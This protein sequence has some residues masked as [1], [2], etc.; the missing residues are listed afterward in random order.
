MYTEAILDKVDHLPGRK[1][2]LTGGDPL[3]HLPW[4][5]ELIERLLQSSYE[6]TIETNGSYPIR[7]YG[8]NNM[9]RVAT[10]KRQG[11]CTQQQLSGYGSV[12]FV[13]DYKLPSSEME[14]KM[15]KENWLDLTKYDVVKFVIGT[16]EDFE[17]ALEVI[18]LNNHCKAQMVI[19][20]AI[21]LTAEDPME[22]PRE[23]AQRLL[24]LRSQSAFFGAGKKL[25]YSLQI[26]KILWPDA[27]ATDER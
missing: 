6:V 19:S 20:P 9:P 26:H 27:T 25:H 24:D 12:R 14:D 23:V 15:V 13:V 8:F 10:V 11:A 21:D 7:R 22:W 17:R 3:Y 18:G 4:I 1:V 5:L 2:T 16:G